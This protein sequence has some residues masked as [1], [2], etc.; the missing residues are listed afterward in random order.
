MK[1]IIKKILEERGMSA[2]A[3]N[4]LMAAKGYQLSD[5]SIRNIINEVHSPK[6]ETLQEIANTL[7][8]SIVDLFENTSNDNLETIYIKDSEGNY[9]EIGFLKK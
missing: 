1:L 9:K 7:N 8:I 2:S 4:R 6:L 3:L 5:I